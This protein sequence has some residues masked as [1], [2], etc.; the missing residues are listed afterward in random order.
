ML[1]RKTIIFLALLLALLL[2]AQWLGE[3]RF[4]AAAADDDEATTLVPAAPSRATSFSLRAG[5][6]SVEIVKILHAL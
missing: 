6:L 5:D 4:A 2:A 3:S 1:S